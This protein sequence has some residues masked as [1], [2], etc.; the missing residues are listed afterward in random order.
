MPICTIT[1]AG[2]FDE[3]GRPLNVGAQYNCTLDQMRSLIQA[4]FATANNPGDLIDG[5]QDALQAPTDPVTGNSGPLVLGNTLSLLPNATNPVVATVSSN[6]NYT[7]AYN[8]NKS[9]GANA[10]AD[11]IAYPDNGTDA[12]GWA[13]IGMTSSGFTQAAYAVTVANEG[14]FFVS[15]PTGS[16]KTGNMVLA[17]DSTGTANKIQLA[18]GGFTTKNNVRV[19]ID[20]TGLAVIRPG[21][22][23]K[24]SEGA[25]GK[26]GTATLV[27]GVVTVANT[28]ITAN[29]RIFVQRQTD[30]GTVAAS[31]SI[32]RTVGTNFTITA[33]D[34]AGAAQVLDT[35]V[36]AFQIFEPG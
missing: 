1:K 19:E 20:A 3:Y 16:G 11:F 9:S 2:R 18:T 22:G 32:T 24:V 36:I 27:A 21:A 5:W 14:Y 34:G 29:S 31:Y 23:L 35:S 12:A 8:W 7:Q 30:G 15:S 6:N 10:S 17:T 26:Q 28:S 33:R 25:N 4:G 13:D